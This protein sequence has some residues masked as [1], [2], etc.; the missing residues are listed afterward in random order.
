MYDLVQSQKGCW[1]TDYQLK[2]YLVGEYSDLTHKEPLDKVVNYDE[3]TNFV[4]LEEVEYEEE[5]DEAEKEEEEKKRHH[6]KKEKTKT[7]HS[8]VGPVFLFALF[9]I[10]ILHL[11]RQKQNEDRH[12]WKTNQMGG[13]RNFDDLD[14]E[15]GMGYSDDVDGDDDNESDSSEEEEVEIPEWRHDDNPETDTDRRTKD[16]MLMQMPRRTTKGKGTDKKVSYDQDF[17]L[18]WAL[19]TDKLDE[20]SEE[21]SDEEQINFADEY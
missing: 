11:V 6:I 1:K 5:E 8:I 19:G 21:D 16:K 2:D 14:A 15:Y 17:D 9:G 20:S 13:G 3:S 12:L 7:H 10:G 18:S 4:D